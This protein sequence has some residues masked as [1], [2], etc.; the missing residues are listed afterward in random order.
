MNDAHNRA[1]EAVEA[2]KQLARTVEAIKAVVQ[3]LDSDMQ[4]AIINAAVETCCGSLNALEVHLFERL[5]GIVS[6]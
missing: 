3:L 4:D 5:K 1:L 6:N 2:A